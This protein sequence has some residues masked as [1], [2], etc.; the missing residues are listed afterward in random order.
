MV[1][2]LKQL[3]LLKKINVP[4]WFSTYKCRIIERQIKTFEIAHHTQFIWTISTR[5]CKSYQGWLQVCVSFKCSFV[6]RSCR[7]SV[8]SSYWVIIPAPCFIE[9]DTLKGFLLAHPSFLIV[10]IFD[11]SYQALHLQKDAASFLFSPA[12][13]HLT[14][15]R[16]YSCPKCFRAGRIVTA[17]THLL[18]SN[19]QRGQ[20]GRGIDLPARGTVNKASLSHVCWAIMKCKK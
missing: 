4:N 5:N 7:R 1:M 17:N 18:L 3:N 9:P 6:T 13:I 2:S 8:A 14:A 10:L 16:F 12:P 15:F 11:R 20:S 19:Y